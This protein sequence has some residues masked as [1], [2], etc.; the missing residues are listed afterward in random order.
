VK[1]NL[2]VLFYDADLDPYSTRV[3]FP[4]PFIDGI[5]SNNETRYILNT[6]YLPLSGPIQYIYYDLFSA[7]YYD[8]TLPYR[9]YFSQDY[10]FLMSKKEAFSKSYLDKLTSEHGVYLFKD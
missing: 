1:N 2:K 4:T 3:I 5:I 6:K 8:D 10:I 7:L 9:V